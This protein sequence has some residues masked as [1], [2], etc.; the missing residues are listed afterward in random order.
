MVTSTNDKSILHRLK[1]IT[2]EKFLGDAGKKSSYRVEGKKYIVVPGTDGRL[3]E[4]PCWY[5]PTLPLTVLGPGEFIQKRP[6]LFE[7]HSIYSNDRSGKGYLKF[8]GHQPTGNV[9]LDTVYRNKKSYTKPLI[10]PDELKSKEHGKEDV[11]V[12]EDVNA[13]IDEATSIL[14][15]HHLNHEH[16]RKVSDAHKHVDGIPAIKHPY[17]CQGSPIFLET[18]P[19]KNSIRG[20]NITYL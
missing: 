5:T 15:H 16:R 18:K 6:E 7:A 3:V 20:G 17:D 1:K 8:H 12:T 4:I 9:V 2:F 11:C 19:K 10:R 14:W 13:M